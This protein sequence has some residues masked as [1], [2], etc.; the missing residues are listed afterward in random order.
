VLCESQF[1][2]IQPKSLVNSVFGLARSIGEAE[3][4]SWE[5]AKNAGLKQAWENLGITGQVGYK[6]QNA[7]PQLVDYQHSR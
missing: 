6:A 7:F 1:T 3:F 4:S 2:I 5:Q